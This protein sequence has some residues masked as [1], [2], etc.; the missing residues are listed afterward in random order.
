MINSHFPLIPPQNSKMWDQIE[1][2]SRRSEQP[3]LV[4]QR[5]CIWLTDNEVEKE[6][7]NKEFTYKP[8]GPKKQGEF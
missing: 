8:A 5:K 7:W 3:F 2:W 6:T 1:F 4:G